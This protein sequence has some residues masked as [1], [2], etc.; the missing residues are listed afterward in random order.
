MS[1]PALALVVA[2]ADND[3]I[4]R[5][6]DLPWK[7]PADLAHFKRVT[8]GK[9]ILMGRRT[10]DSIG[11]ALPGRSNIV[12]TRD[13]SFEA[14]GV[15]V[16]HGLADALALAGDIA[17]CDGASEIM[18]IGGA[19]IYSAA[20]PLADRLYLTRVHLMPPGDTYLPRIDW[21]EWIETGREEAVQSDTAPAHTFLYYTRT[22][23]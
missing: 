3:V 2:A 4:G 17:T 22:P 8:M 7:L 16:V 19:Q 6:N 21:S 12:M 20:L 5:G 18:V 10:F 9:P 14:A 11:R 23:G 1:A 15:R 13:R